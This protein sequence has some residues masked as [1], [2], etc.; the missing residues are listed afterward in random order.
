MN[1]H[2]LKTYPH[3]FKQSIEGKKLFEI[4]LNDRNFQVGD[5]VILKEWDNIKYSGRELRGVIKY[6]LDDKFIGIAKGYVALSLEFFNGG[7]H[8]H[9]R[10][11]KWI[12]HRDT[13]GTITYSCSECCVAETTRRGRVLKFC[14]NCGAKM[15]GDKN[16]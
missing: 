16:V 1:V 7:T 4:R 6:I 14:P 10:H 15:D 13:V 3:Y 11:R 2:E 9:V 5:I 8:G 12:F